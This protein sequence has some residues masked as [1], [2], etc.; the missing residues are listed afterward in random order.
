MRPGAR[1]VA[2]EPV[3]AAE[4]NHLE[5]FTVTASARTAVEKVREREGRRV[6]VGAPVL[7]ERPA[8]I[9]T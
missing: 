7:Q 4:L 9:P 5:L 1:D 3:Q 2:T 8:E 6:A